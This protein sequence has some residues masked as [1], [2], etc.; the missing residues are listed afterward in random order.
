MAVDEAAVFEAGLAPD[1]ATAKPRLLK[2]A[3]RGSVAG[4][5][6]GLEPHDAAP[7][8][9]VGDGRPQRLRHDAPA[10]QVLGQPIARLGVEPFDIAARREGD[11]ADRLAVHVDAVVHRLRAGR[12]G[13]D[14]ALGVAARIG[15]GQRVAAVVP[16]VSVVE[17]P[18]QRLAVRR[19]PASENRPIHGARGV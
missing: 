6:D 1:A 19:L 4:I 2:H 9:T 12:R 17:V 5:D 11:A 14:E 15:V 16:D 18:G 7:A 10:P 13:A 3:H 8:E